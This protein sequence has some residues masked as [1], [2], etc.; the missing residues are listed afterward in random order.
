MKLIVIKKVSGEL[1]TYCSKNPLTIKEVYE[2][3]GFTSRTNGMAATYIAK[4]FEKG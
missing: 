4:E 1:K 2:G 3:I